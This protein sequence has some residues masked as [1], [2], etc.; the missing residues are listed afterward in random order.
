MQ[1][2]VGP[3]ILCWLDP[4]RDVPHLQPSVSQPLVS[5]GEEGEE[6][7]GLSRGG[8]P[9]KEGLRLR[10]TGEGSLQ[11]RGEPSPKHMPRRFP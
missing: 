10:R 1:G 6:S 5:R 4:E 2:V 9:Q 7:E 8:M 11:H 3:R